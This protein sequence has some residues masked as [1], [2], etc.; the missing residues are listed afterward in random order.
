MLLGL[1]YAGGRPGGPAITAA[2]YGFVCRYLSDGGP[3]LPGK[4]LTAAEYTDLQ[5]HGVAVVVNWESSADRMKAGRAAGI[6][7]AVDAEAVASDLGVPADRPIY[8]SADWDATPG[9]QVLIDAYLTGAASVI[10]AGRVGVYGGYWVVSRCLDNHTATWAWQTGAWSPTNPD[11]SKKVDPRAHLYQ[12]TTGYAFVGGV[13]CDV[14]EALTIDFGQHP[15]QEDDM[16]ADERAALYDVR[17]QLTGSRSSTP[18]EYAGW[19]ARADLTTAP[20]TL[21]D[22]IRAVHAEVLSLHAEV[23]AL[24]ATPKA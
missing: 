8:F 14:N 10:G 24:S 9:D 13:E 16:Q 20:K 21:V 11:G 6:S 4:L 15:P 7:D 17:E 19:P 2:G 22:Y 5:A 3:D 12:R 23:A 18:P 1:D